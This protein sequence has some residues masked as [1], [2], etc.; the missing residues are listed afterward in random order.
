MMSFAADLSHA[1]A[2]LILGV[3]GALLLLLSLLRRLASHRP[4]CG[5]IPP[6]VRRQPDPC[7]YSQEFLTSRVPPLPVTWDNPDIWI[8]ELTGASVSSADL[9]P[10]HDYQVVCR[11]W[12]ASFYPAF[13]VSV[14]C[15]FAEW[16]FGPGI[17]QPVQVEATGA[18]YIAS[19]DIGPWTNRL[20]TFAW[21][22]PPTGGH[23]CLYV[24]CAHPDDVTTANNVGQENTR[25][26]EVAPMSSNPLT[27]VLTNTSLTNALDVSFTV[28]AYQITGARQP[29]RVA[30]Q[31]R[32]LFRTQRR[33]Q[34][35]QLFALTEA[36]AFAD[37][38]RRAAAGPVGWQL[39]VDGSPAERGLRLAPGEQRHVVLELHHPSGSGTP[40]E[41]V[42]NVTARG[43]NGSLV[44]GVS[45]YPRLHG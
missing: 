40:S 31:G 13:G 5:Q 20:A 1:V 18:E 23:Y 33:S 36:S 45:I 35:R 6:D 4:G 17:E 9:Q 10:S 29:F 21:R 28:D 12:N 30:S 7:L 26:L 25:V 34:L 24:R 42:V 14:T 32:V 16:G 2:Y 37:V 15:H 41:T 19:L 27:A 43:G 38:Q 3:L 8:T 11:I 39:H 22:T 44:G